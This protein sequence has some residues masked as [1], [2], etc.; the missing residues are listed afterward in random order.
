MGMGMATAIKLACFKPAELPVLV[1]RRTAVGRPLRTFCPHPV[2]GS[3][4]SCWGTRDGGLETN[5]PPLDTLIP[6]RVYDGEGMAC[7]GS[8]QVQRNGDEPTAPSNAASDPCKCIG[9]VDIPSG[10][11]ER[12]AS[13]ASPGRGAKPL[14]PHPARVVDET[15]YGHVHNQPCLPMYRN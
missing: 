13:P 3:P 2:R 8:A 15:S 11:G 4:T 12:E 7:V 5:T 10:S 1:P 14:C 9:S 6:P